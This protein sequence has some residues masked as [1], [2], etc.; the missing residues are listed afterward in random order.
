[1]GTYVGDQEPHAHGADD[2]EGA[3]DQE[4]DLPALDLVV[5]GCQH[6]AQGRVADGGAG[7]AH[8]SGEAEE[9]AA[10]RRRERL[11]RDEKVAITGADRQEGLE[12]GVK[13]DEE[14]ED[15]LQRDHGAADSKAEAADDSPAQC[16]RLPAADTVH[17]VGAKKRTRKSEE[18]DQV[19][20]ADAT[21]QRRV[22]RKARDE[23]RRQK[24]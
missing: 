18:V 15:V 19:A 22:G 9:V 13:D 1:M 6:L 4:D 14:R 21:Q 8:G 7:L 5:V 2:G 24:V 12:E 23:R 10:E 20:P 3:S 16:V 11:G 17:Q